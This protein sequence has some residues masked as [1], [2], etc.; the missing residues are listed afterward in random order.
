M[1]EDQKRDDETPTG[2]MLRMIRNEILDEAAA[3]ALDRNHW[4]YN[5]ESGYLTAATTAKLIALAIQA[6]KT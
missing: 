1:T 6:L 2:F 5:D 4:C 3:C